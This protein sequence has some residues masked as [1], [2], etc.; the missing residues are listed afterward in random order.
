MRQ[1]CLKQFNVKVI[2]KSIHD[3][4]VFSTCFSTG[5]RTPFCHQYSIFNIIISKDKSRL[6]SLPSAVNLIIS[7]IRTTDKTSKPKD[8]PFGQSSMGSE[9]KKKKIRSFIVAALFAWKPF[10]TASWQCMHSTWTKINVILQF[11]ATALSNMNY[12]NRN[13]QNMSIII[14]LTLTPSVY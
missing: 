2:Y 1:V 4:H 5:K 7:Q 10:Y 8:N 9:K 6:V 3:R 13:V 14:L 11:P 12:K